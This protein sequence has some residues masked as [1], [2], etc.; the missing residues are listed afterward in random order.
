[1]GSVSKEEGR[2]KKRKLRWRIWRW[3]YMYICEPLLTW[4]NSSRRDAM[5]GWILCTIL[6]FLLL[7]HPSSFRLVICYV[8]C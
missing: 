8:R 3:F 7:F 6:L 5:D 4:T 2:M 1:M